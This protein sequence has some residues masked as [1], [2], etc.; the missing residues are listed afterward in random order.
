M[1]RLKNGMIVFLYGD[2]Y[3]LLDIEITN[4]FPLIALTQ[5]THL[6]LNSNEA[7]VLNGF[8]HLSVPPDL[9]LHISSNEE[10]LFFNVNEV[11]EMLNRKNSIPY[12]LFTIVGLPAINASPL[13]AGIWNEAMVI[14]PLTDSD[15]S[16]STRLFVDFFIH[17]DNCS[18]S[19]ILNYPFVHFKMRLARTRSGSSLETVHLSEIQ[20]KAVQF[21][22]IFITLRFGYVELEDEE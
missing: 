3:K 22:D 7:Q 11:W 12:R 10:H 20:R 21:A 5:R 1:T 17:H 18:Y 6:V 13:G 15:F 19:A 16:Q 14:P 9:R 2:G 4:T 8:E